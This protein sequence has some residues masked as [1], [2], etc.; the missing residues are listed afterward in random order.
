V[1]LWQTGRPEEA[2]RTFRQA[3]ASRPDYYDAHY[4]LGTVLRQLGDSQ[5][6]LAQFREAIRL[7]PSSP[8]A[9]LSLGQLLQQHGDASAAG[10]AFEEAQRL[11]QKKAD[12]EA[13]TFAVGAGRGSTVRTRHHSGAR[14]LRG[15]F[16]TG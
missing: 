11:R 4:M 8:E 2:V 15:A 16:R 3:I 7:R 14:Q 12:V 9:H 1:V 6:A 5:S 13:S 10:A